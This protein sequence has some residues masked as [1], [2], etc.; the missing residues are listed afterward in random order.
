MPNELP[1]E[2]PAKRRRRKPPHGGPRAGAGRKPLDPSGVARTTRSFQVTPEEYD[3]LRAHL[4]FMR[5]KK[6]IDLCE[7]THED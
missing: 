1:V 7:A 3:A 4:A 2:A 5:E 6:A